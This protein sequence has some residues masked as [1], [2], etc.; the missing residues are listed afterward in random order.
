MN[1][2]AR[3]MLI[4]LSFAALELTA[5]LVVSDSHAQKG[6]PYAKSF[7]KAAAPRARL[8]N[9]RI[10][11]AKSSLRSQPVRGWRF[12]KPGL[13]QLKNN[14]RQISKQVKGSRSL[15]QKD[16][17]KK[18]KRVTDNLRRRNQPRPEPKPS[19]ARGAAKYRATQVF[20][21]HKAAETIMR[22]LKTDIRK[23]LNKGRLKTHFQKRVNKGRLTAEFQKRVKGALNEI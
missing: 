18:I 6:V 22:K 2:V 9:S 20:R 17:V 15:N 4:A 19:W 23:S 11:I 3:W 12:S 14:V 13:R 7:N 1:T 5:G 16:L 8:P 10:N 21:N